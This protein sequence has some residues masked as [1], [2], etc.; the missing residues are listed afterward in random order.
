MKQ[1]SDDYSVRIYPFADDATPDS[2]LA[3]MG[4]VKIITDQ[5]LAE[6]QKLDGK[7]LFNIQ[8]RT[9]TRDE[10]RQLKDAVDAAFDLLVD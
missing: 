4:Y 7:V 9:L 3:S 2:F 5:A 8:L 10:W 6:E 1:E